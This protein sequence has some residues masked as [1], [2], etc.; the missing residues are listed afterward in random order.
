MSWALQSAAAPP[1]SAA[2]EPCPD[3]ETVFARG[4]A[5]E[6]GLGPTGQAFVDSLRPKIGT[7][8]LG[9]YAVNYPATDDWPTGI[10]GVRDASAH[11]LSTAATCPK[12]KMVLGGFSQ[13]AAVMGFVTANVI[14]DGVGGP[15][16]P[17]PMPPEVADHV[18][19]VT[20][21]GTPNERAMNF[22][23][24]P[25]VVIGPLYAAKTVQL[26]APEDPVCSEGMNF[27][28][29]T[30]GEYEGMVDEGAAYAAGR[31]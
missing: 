24:E 23:G 11:I 30:P 13:G 19:A 20:L 31:L 22:L 27:A 17:Q 9:V 18:A 28:A 25:P 7:K 5:E 4:T 16:L 8:S 2:G 15:D 12:T 14:P 3:V 21:F 10:D 1:A 6:P 26:C 29:H